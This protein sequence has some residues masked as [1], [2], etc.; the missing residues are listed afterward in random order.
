MKKYEPK[1]TNNKRINTPIVNNP[2]SNESRFWVFSFKYFR[3]I[4][5]FGL[6]NEDTKWFM[7]LID[8]LT[9]L[10]S[11]QVE[12]I[13]TDSQ[14]K[15]NLRYHPIDWNAKNIPLKR[16]DFKWLPEEIIENN[17]EI[18]FYQF[19]ISQAKGRVIGFWE[20]NKRQFNIVLLD[21][22]HNMQPS[23]LYSYK[24]D[25]TR[26]LQTEYTSLLASVDSLRRKCLRN[27]C[28]NHKKELENLVNN[29]NSTNFVCF[30]LDD[31]FQDLFYENIK[32]K[33]IREI[34]ETGL[35]E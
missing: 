5:N 12:R 4:D 23:K 17:E 1:I 24:V 26:S 31:D 34:F 3:Q 28:C 11:I 35:I 27:K 2:D 32:D 29:N 6:G 14:L 18:P 19:Q 22:K 20:A 9:S 33:S 25:F 8:K 21:Q 10:S 7:S 30:Q 15:D 13:E 16:E